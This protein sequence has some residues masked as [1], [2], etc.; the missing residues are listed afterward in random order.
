MPKIAFLRMGFWV[1]AAMVISFSTAISAEMA[2]DQAGLD[3]PSAASAPEVNP[4]HLPN[5]GPASQVP[6]RH[7]APTDQ[8]GDATRANT[9][10]APAKAVAGQ[11]IRS[12]APSATATRRTA[13][14][15]HDF[16]IRPTAYFRSWSGIW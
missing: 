16:V 13:Y 14:V 6:A 5:Y 4:Q 2:E 8:F 9:A 7:G 15:T 12:A 1:V 10:N 3:P 11:G